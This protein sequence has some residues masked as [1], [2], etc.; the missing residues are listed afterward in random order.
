MNPSVLSFVYIGSALISMYLSVKTYKRSKEILANN[1]SLLLATAS[2]WSFFYGVEIAGSTIHFIRVCLSLEYIG[3]VLLPVFWFLYAL[4]YSGN[5]NLIRKKNVPILFIIP[6]INYIAEITNKYHFL[7]YESST[8]SYADGYWYHSLTPGIFYYLHLFYSYTLIIAGIYMVMRLYYTISKEYRQTISFI[9]I[10][11]LIPCIISLMY[12][13]GYKPHGFI[14]LTP[15]GFLAMG[16]TLIIGVYN[17]NLFDIKPLALNSLFDS[18]PD[19][20]VVFN[21]NKEITIT[22]PAAKQ[23]LDS[24]LFKKEGILQ[25]ILL[26]ENTVDNSNDLCYDNE[27]DVGNK[28]YSIAFN[29]VRS[30]TNAVLGKIL[31]L[32]DITEQKQALELQQL[33]VEIADTYINTPLETLNTTINQ[34]LSRIGQFVKADRS[35]IFSY[36]WEKNNC[37]NTYEWCAEG[38][39]EEINH[40][41]NISL[42][43]MPEWIKDHRNGKEVFSDD[44]STIKTDSLTKELLEAQNIKSLLTIPLMD[45]NECIGFVGFDSVKKAHKYTNKERILLQVFAQMI[46]NL[47]NRKKANE[48]LDNQIKVQQ[49]INE[50]SSELV[51]VDNKNLDE[52]I[53]KILQKTGD[54]FQVDRSYILRYY[55]DLDFETNTHEW[56]AAHI[57]SQKESITNAKLNQFPWWKKQIEKKQ[58][59]HIPDAELLPLEAGVEKKDF[60]RQG[61]QSLLCIPIINNNNLIGYFGFDSV[62]TKRSW[63]NSQIHVIETITNILGDALIKV[64]TELE[65]IRSKELAESASMA[66]TEFLSNMSHEIRTPLNGV[67]G[68]TDLLRNTTLTKVQK[69]YLD[70][71]ITSANSLLGVISDILDFSKIEVGKLELD[72]VRTDIIQLLENAI[73][74]VKIHASNKGLELLLNI[75]PDAARFAWIDP[76]RLKQILVNLM[77]NAVKFTAIGEVELKVDFE[78]INQHKGRYKISIR[79]TGI[80][81]KEDQKEKLFKAFSQADTSTTRRYGG[82]GLGLI[83]SNSLA[84]KMGSQITFESTY[85]VGSTF[86]FDIETN[87]EYGDELA[88]TGSLKHIKNALIIDDNLN[89]RTILEHTFNYWGIPTVSCQ[90]GP[91]AIKMASGSETEFDL[92]IVDYHMPYLNG[93]ETIRT[94]RNILQKNNSILNEPVILLHSSLDDSSVHKHAHESD[95]NYLLTKP[96]KADELYNYLTNITAEHNQKPVHLLSK[97]QSYNLAISGTDPVKILVAE[98]TRMNMILIT[99]ILSD[100]IPNVVIIEALNG[101]EACN[102]FVSEKIDLVLMDVQMPVMDGID[103]TKKIRSMFGADNLPIIA[104][105]AGVTKEEREK[106]FSV[107]MNG[108]LSKPIQKN[109]LENI[110]IEHLNLNKNELTSVNENKEASAHFDKKNLLSKTGNSDNIFADMVNLS[111]TEFPKYINELEVAIQLLDPDKIKKAAHKLKGSAYNMDFNIMGDISADIEKNTSPDSFSGMLANLKKEWNTI[112]E[113]L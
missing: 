21:M 53:Q 111:K 61:I 6:V 24:K 27:I 84:E 58:I 26:K 81:I 19:A 102:A 93:I 89:N 33:L 23:L 103:A 99:K 13:F 36:D 52:K 45:E 83:I 25:K 112:Y 17:N 74:I 49:L 78:K 75:Q 8:I 56:C 77:G 20:I 44:I 69:D 104:L 57:Q 108:F 70:N 2:I 3:I 71:A 50:I 72:I 16:L 91:E 88:H 35:Y 5:E 51:S 14:D 82:T 59:I 94:L 18:I 43:L 90:N 85:E 106:C 79:D 1:I 86:H 80:G 96:V 31:I 110:L 100:L 11:A 101:E 92:I 109:E 32:H 73:D 97:K 37:S 62:N 54:F 98:D 48:L 95:I 34:S 113:I 7:F 42:D 105:S 4:N 60:K 47:T 38:V 15:L 87:F 65:V 66:K 40:L 12:V 22:N 30:R 41:Q 46:V 64:E 68:F 29:K 39:N 63:L 67:I 10:G 28:T 76:I 107:G 9:I 55:D